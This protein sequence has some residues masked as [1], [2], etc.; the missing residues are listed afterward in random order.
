MASETMCNYIESFLT[1]RAQK[2]RFLH[3][4]DGSYCVLTGSGKIRVCEGGILEINGGILQ[5]ADLELIPGCQVIIKNNGKINMAN[6][7]SFDVPVGAF[8]D[9]PYG[10]VN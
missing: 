9:I 8:V 4:R 7:K 3:R 10:S 1:P 5:D 6:G 2:G